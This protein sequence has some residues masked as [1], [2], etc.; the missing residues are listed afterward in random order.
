MSL[1]QHV[2]NGPRKADLE[3]ILFAMQKSRAW[4]SLFALAPG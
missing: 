2:I 3:M 4:P 1:A